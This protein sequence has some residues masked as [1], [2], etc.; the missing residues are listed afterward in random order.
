M[1]ESQRDQYLINIREIISYHEDTRG[2]S[3][4]EMIVGNIKGKVKVDFYHC[5]KKEEKECFIPDQMTGDN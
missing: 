3:M 1:E 5:T 4:I 2:Y